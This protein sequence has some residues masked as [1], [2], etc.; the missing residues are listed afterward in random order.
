MRLRVLSA[1][2][3]ALSVLTLSLPAGPPRRTVRAITAVEP[4]CSLYLDPHDS[5]TRVV[6]EPLPEGQ[7]LTSNAVLSNITVNYTGFTSQAQAAFQA[8]VDIW[9]TQV[10]STVPIVIDATFSNLGSSG[11]LGQAGFRNVFAN[12]PGAPLADVYY[13]GPIA[14]KRSNL[15]LNGSTTEIAASFNSTASWN[16]GTDGVPVSG[17]VDFVSVV[18]HELGHGL[19]FVGTGTVSGSGL[20]NVGSIYP[21]VYDSNVVDSAGTSILNTAVYP[22]N[23]TKLAALLMGTGVSGPGLFWSGAAGAAGNA[24][25][26]P[27][28]Y[29]PSGYQAGSTYSHLDESTYP[30]GDINSLM[31]PVIHYAEVIHTPG[32]IVAGMYGDMGWGSQ[33]SFGLDQAVAG[34]AAGGGTVTVTLIATSGCPWT[35]STTSPFVTIMA[36][37][38]GST[39]A[40]VSL[41]VSAN[42]GAAARTATVAIGD[43]TLTIGQAGTTPCAYALNPVSASVGPAGASGSVTLATTAGC[44]WTALS[45]DAAVA[46]ATPFTGIGSGTVGYTVTGNVGGSARL[47]TLTIGGQ[48]FA[49]SQSA[50]AYALGQTSAPVSGAGGT[51]SVGVTAASSCQWTASTASSYVSVTS[52]ASGAGNGTAQLLV[53]ANPTIAARSATATVAGQTVTITQGA[54]LPTMMLDRSV[55]NFGVLPGPSSTRTS[56][57]MLR[58]TQGGAPGTVTWTAASNQSWLTVSPASGSGSAV[59][60]AAV[61]AAGAFPA[62]QS[63]TITLTYSGAS[64]AGATVAVSLTALPNGLGAPT[65]SFDTPLN[66]AAGVTG[67]IAVTGWAVDDVEVTAVKI[68]RDPVAPEPAGTLVFVGDAVFVDGA[69][70][71]I[72]SLYAALP[73]FTRGGWGYLLLTNFLPNGGNGT[74][75]L[76]AIAYDADGHGTTLGTKTITCANNAATTP[77]GAIDT[78]LQGETVSGTINNF[79]WVL[80]RT[81]RADVPGG[82]TVS[83][84]IDGAVVGTPVGWTS[85]AD[86]TSLFPPAQFAGVTSSLAVFT[87]DT[88]TLSNGVHTI[89][90]VVTDNQGAASG[91]GSRYF[92]VSNGA[93]LMLDPNSFRLTAFAEAS[94]VTKAEATEVDDSWLPPSAFA[95]ASADRRS[96]GG[97]WSGGRIIG[98]RGF[99][100]AAPYRTYR[101]GADGVITIQSE[102]LDRIELLLGPGATAFGRDGDERR[103]LPIGSH[104]DPETGTFTWQPGVG[105]VGAHDFV[106]AGRD[107]RIVLNAKGSGRVGPQTVIDLAEGGLVAGWAADLDSQVDTGVDTVHVWAYPVDGRDPIFLGAAEYGGR[108]P[109]VAAIYGA[110]FLKSGYGLRVEGLAPG[111]YDVAVFAYST[112]TGGFVPA[113]TARITVR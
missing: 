34:A 48:P 97:G 11:L 43:Q 103:P 67:S 88:T 5:F 40:V 28:L 108:R 73:R 6:P 53:A 24:G 76:K 1:V 113:K 69:R 20:G 105:F 79:G 57:Q 95:E 92:T 107:V 110:R 4:F 112:V 109:D 38:S 17:K 19:G 96:L 86:L 50:C 94:A 8:A 36:G 13:P 111:T 101:P 35:A 87:L 59:L 106:L 58:L 83:V 72:A 85:R 71:D 75:N 89:S 23:S 65:G 64:T 55:L 49:I 46:S 104:L 9:R 31:T 14:N 54:G 102:E 45:S 3:L 52:G 100:L 98:R 22:I 18:L 80:S 60:T 29:A 27:R 99:D 7:A 37:A 25:S 66:N 16:Y 63:A 70:P 84:V 78:P 47:A 26:R 15:D 10:N 91:V 90:W 32:P 30:S 44:V 33:C 41:N 93:G 74:F 51:V 62:G 21:Y 77:F 61:A 12:F 2:A 68:F 81:A 39:S 56:G 42:P 82:G